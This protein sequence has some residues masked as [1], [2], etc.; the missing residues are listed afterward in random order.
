MLIEIEGMEINYN[1]YENCQHETL[2]FMS[3]DY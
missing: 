3:L 2:S 1:S